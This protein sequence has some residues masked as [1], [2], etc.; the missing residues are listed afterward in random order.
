MTEMKNM[1]KMQKTQKSPITLHGL[2]FVFL[3]N[4]KKMKIEIFAFS[5]I[6]FNPIKI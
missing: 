3:Q 1:Q 4:R 6:T 5:V 2:C